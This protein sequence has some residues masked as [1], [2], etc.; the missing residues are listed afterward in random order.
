VSIWF[1]EVLWLGL[2]LCLALWTT[3]SVPVP[4]CLPSDPCVAF[5]IYLLGSGSLVSLVGGVEWSYPCWDP[6]R[7]V[8]LHF[9]IPFHLF[10]FYIRP[11]AML[12]V[13]QPVG[14]RLVAARL[15]LG[16]EALLVL[17]VA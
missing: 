1:S 17:P 3:C 6:A 11:H 15:L 2:W 9:V 4:D 12:L 7:F 10:T 14:D 8:L 16:Q 13:L 5:W